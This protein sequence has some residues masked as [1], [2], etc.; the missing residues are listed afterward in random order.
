[1]TSSPKAPGV[2]PEEAR[3]VLPRGTACPIG[4]QQPKSDGGE[5]RDRHAQSN[6]KRQTRPASTCTSCRWEPAD[7]VS[8]LPAGYSKPSLP[9]MSTEPLA[10]SITPPCRSQSAATVTWSRWRQSGTLRTPSAA[11]SA[12][13]RSPVRGWV[14]SCYSAIGYDG[15]ATAAS[16]TWKKP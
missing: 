6:A 9:T 4:Q 12:R 15:G 1:M 5:G 8:G 11:Q 13:V 2:L 10:T 7:S 14:A 16:P 3:S